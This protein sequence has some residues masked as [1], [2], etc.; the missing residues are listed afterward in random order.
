MEIFPPW[1]AGE[2]R[3]QVKSKLGWDAEAEPLCVLL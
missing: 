1:E 2:S 3:L